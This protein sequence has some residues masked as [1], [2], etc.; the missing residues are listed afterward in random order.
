[1]RLVAP[2]T[3]VSLAFGRMALVSLAFGRMALVSLAFV[4]LAFGT[5]AHAQSPPGAELRL[6]ETAAPVSAERTH[7]G[8]PLAGPPNVTLAGAPTPAP[9]LAPP[10]IEL[11]SPLVAAPAA[12]PPR[13]P[14]ARHWWFWAGLGT[15]AVGVVL[16]AI[17]LGPRDPYSGNATPGTVQIF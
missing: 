11:P 7:E 12:K 14:L 3:F 1:L 9:F 4:S 8:V 16:A 10:V 6:A 2:K 13:V 15:A 5:P 17:Y